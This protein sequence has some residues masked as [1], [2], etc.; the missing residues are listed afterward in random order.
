[1]QKGNKS[2]HKV[3][4]LI[5]SWKAKAGSP[6]CPSAALLTRYLDIPATNER[7]SSMFVTPLSIASMT[8]QLGTSL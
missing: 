4:T 7:C 8:N 5:E 3:H 2:H 1:M 6:A